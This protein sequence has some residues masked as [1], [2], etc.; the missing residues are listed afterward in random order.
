MERACKDC[1]YW[2]GGVGYCRRYPPTPMNN[3]PITEDNQWCGEF[4]SRND[5]T[6]RP[7]PLCEFLPTAAEVQRLI[8]DLEEL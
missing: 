8:D 7:H 3:W 5:R 4:R 1:D 2:T 6:P